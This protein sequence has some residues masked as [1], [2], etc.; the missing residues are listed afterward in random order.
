MNDLGSL[1]DVLTFCSEASKYSIIT[2]NTNIFSHNIFDKN[3]STYERCFIGDEEVI[4]K[5]LITIHSSKNNITV[6]DIRDTLLSIVKSQKFNK[7]L[8]SERSYCF[9]GFQKIRS[10]DNDVFYKINWGS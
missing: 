4:V 7:P 1:I 3:L 10:F 6:L 8:S 2:L 9:E 5:D